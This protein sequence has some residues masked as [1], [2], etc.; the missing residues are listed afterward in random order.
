[1]VRDR[2]Y[3]GS[4]RTL[5]EHVAAV[6]PRPRREVYLSTDTMPGEQAQVD[7][8]Y[9]DKHCHK[10]LITA[11]SWRETHPFD[12]DLEKPQDPKRP[13]KRR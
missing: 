7:W 10:L 3:A 8:A 2:G 13:R 5:R 4:I 9:V 1:M 6:R 12:H 11:D